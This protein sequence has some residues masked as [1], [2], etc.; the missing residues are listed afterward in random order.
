MGDR[1]LITGP[2]FLLMGRRKRPLN[3][4]APYQELAQ[5]LRELRTQAGLSYRTMA[6]RISDP[7]CSASTLSRADGGQC[8]PR[9]SVVI[10]Y[11]SACGASAGAMETLWR[12]AR[13]NT[14]AAKGNRNTRRTTTSPWRPAETS[15]TRA[16]VLEL[17]DEPLQLLQAMQQLHRAAGEPSLREL[18]RRA[19]RMRLPALPKS[20]LADILT[21]IRVPTEQQL[22]TFVVCCGEAGPRALRWRSAYQRT[23]RPPVSPGQGAGSLVH[24]IQWS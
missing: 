19:Q 21:G 5:T 12:R 15:T 3:A 16:R 1:V 14:R 2:G 24:R 22:M 23:F 18:Q 4:D 10:A 20:T 13:S 17:I 7:G 9:K 6:D 11:G 8:L